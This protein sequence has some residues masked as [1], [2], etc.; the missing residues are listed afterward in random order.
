MFNVPME[1]P[2]VLLE[3]AMLQNPMIAVFLD[4]AKAKGRD[5]IYEARLLIQVHSTLPVG[6]GACAACM[7]ASVQIPINYTPVCVLWLAGRL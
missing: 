4:Q 7:T 6:C 1:V 5:A 3:E 2:G